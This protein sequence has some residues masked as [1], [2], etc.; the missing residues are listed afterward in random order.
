MIN[1]NQQ[2][3]R[4]EVMPAY[5]WLHNLYALERNSRK[6]RD[7]DQRTIKVQPIETGSL[8]PDTA[9]E[10]IAAIAYLDDCIA[11][12]GRSLGGETRD[13]A[14][15]MA[16]GTAQGTAPESIPEEPAFAAF[17]RSGDIVPIPARG[18]ERGKRDAVI[19][20]PLRGRGAYR[21]MLHYYA[22]KTLAAWLAEKPG[23]GFQDMV[24]TLEEEIA[25]L[26]PEVSEQGHS[27]AR[28]PREWVNMG[29][30]LVPAFRVDRLRRDIGE[31]TI[32]SWDE[33]HQR[34]NAWHDRYPVDRL[35][36]AWGVYCL[37]GTPEGAG[38]KPDQGQF[39]RDLETI[40]ETRQWI[41][42]Q[43]YASRAKDFHDCF[44]RITYRNTGEM[45]QVIGKLEDNPFIIQTR[46]EGRDFEETVRQLIAR[47]G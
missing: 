17:L 28:P 3:N 25:S 34:Y 27:P 31:G 1:N 4:L 26:G 9:E 41:T 14:R 47:L 32:K 22:V 6:S 23:L 20:K 2:K 37:L 43:V 39:I 12:A 36:H 42:G 7:R 45:E 33:I 30:Q 8:A 11:R 16:Q 15:D 40:I 35:C 10:I 21:R 29:G 13:G 19:L 5:Y 44:R 38:G 46:R 24:N 18:L